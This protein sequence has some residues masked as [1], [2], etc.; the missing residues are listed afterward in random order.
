MQNKH[1]EKMKL[2]KEITSI[3]IQLKSMLGLFLYSALIREIN[4]VIKCGYKAIKSCH[5]EKF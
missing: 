1:G 5:E 2:K 3:S 4:H